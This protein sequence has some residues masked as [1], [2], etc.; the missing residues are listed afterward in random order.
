MHVTLCQHILNVFE[1]RGLFFFSN[2]Y[3]YQEEHF[4]KWRQDMATWPQDKT[5]F[6]TENRQNKQKYPH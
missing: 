6:T 3:W 1:H 4:G 2:M 5:Q